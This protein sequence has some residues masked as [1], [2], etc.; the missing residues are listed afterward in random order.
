ML[1]IHRGDGAT[2][3]T[4]PGL[5]LGGLSLVG[6]A[7]PYLLIA[8]GDGIQLVRLI[9]GAAGEVDQVSLGDYVRVEGEKQHEQLFNG[10]E[11]E[12]DP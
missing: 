10:D 1:G 2:L 7:G 6:E 5:D 9:K 11:L 4:V 12:V 8:T 3:Q